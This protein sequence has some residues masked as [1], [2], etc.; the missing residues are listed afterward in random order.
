MN[1]STMPSTARIQTCVHLFLPL[2]NLSLGIQ[3]STHLAKVS[4]VGVKSESNPGPVRKGKCEWGALSAPVQIEEVT[5]MSFSCTLGR[6][7]SRKKV[8]GPRT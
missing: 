5:R 3:R 7:E 6:D 2:G 4:R 1:V 8:S